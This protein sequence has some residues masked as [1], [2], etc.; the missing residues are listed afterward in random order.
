MTYPHVTRA[1]FLDRPNRFTATVRCP[2][3]GRERTV[4]VKNTGRCRELLVPGAEVWLAR[5]LN[6]ARKYPEDLVAVRKGERL[7]NLDAQA[8]NEVGAAYVPHLGPGFTLLRREYPYRDARIDLLAADGG[9]ERWLIEVKGVTL[10]KDGNVYFP[11]APTSR[12]CHH[13]SVLTEAV[14]EGWHAALL[15]VVQMENVRAF[16]PNRRTD[17]AFADGLAKA[18]E[19]GVVLRAVSCRVEPD[20][21]EPDREIPVFLNGGAFG[22]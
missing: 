21:L 16:Y 17:P 4:H 2:E 18:A 11:D 8:P 22:S 5:A 3:T 13:L 9:G 6:P 19:A 20:S 14:R 1:V 7:I 12:G 10:E 15:L